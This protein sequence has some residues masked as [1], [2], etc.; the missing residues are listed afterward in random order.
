MYSWK[1][2]SNTKS[3][4]YQSV[5][6]LMQFIEY[7]TEIGVLQ[8]MGSQRVG[9]YW[10]TELNWTESEASH[11]VLMVK[12]W[13]ANAG[14]I[15]DSGSIP[16]SGR[17]PGGGHGRQLHYSCLRI[18]WTEGPTG[19][20]SIGLQRVRHDCS[21]WTATILNKILG[22][23]IQQRTKKTMFHGQLGFISGKHSWF[24]TW[25]SIC[26]IYHYP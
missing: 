23:W 16:G 12:N 9:Y 22:N 17:C 21:D 6:N 1:K 26:V 25:K 20:Q 15:A 3:I 5:E 11:M 24:N 18:S 4:L 19:L 14:N 13:L 10:V 7:C 8:S 2:S